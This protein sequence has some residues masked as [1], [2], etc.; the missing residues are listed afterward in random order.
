MYLCQNFEQQTDRR[1][2]RDWRVVIF[3]VAWADGLKS[4]L[5]WVR[6]EQGHWQNGSSVQVGSYM[7]GLVDKLPGIPV[8][9]SVYHGKK[10]TSE[11][12]TRLTGIQPPM[13][14]DF[15]MEVEDLDDVEVRNHF[16]KP[17]DRKRVADKLR[18]RFYSV[19]TLEQVRERINRESGYE[20]EST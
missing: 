18:R 16:R 5:K 9:K 8:M 7:I 4:K 11:E 20:E 12:A 14:L 2:R 15:L 17:A 1:Y 6:Y 13:G 19:S 3:K 10:V